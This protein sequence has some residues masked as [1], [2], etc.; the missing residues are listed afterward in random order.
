SKTSGYVKNLFFLKSEKLNWKNESP[1]YVR[2]W[3]NQNSITISSGKYITKERWSFT[4]K[5]K[6]VL[7]LEREKMIRSSLDLLQLSIEKKHIEMTRQGPASFSL[8][9]LK[10]EVKGKPKKSEI[11]IMEILQLHI[12]YFKKKASIKERS[13][14]TLQKYKRSK[15]LLG[16]F[17][18]KGYNRDDM[19]WTKINSPFIHNLESFLKYESDFNGRIGIKN[20]SVVKYM[21][22]YKTALIYALKMNLITKNLFDLYTGR[23]KEKNAVFLTQEELQK[24]EQKNIADKRLERVK[25][26]FIFCCYTGYAPI[27]VSSL[28]EKNLV[29]DNNDDL[30]IQMNRIK[31]AVKS[32]V[33]LLPPVQ[34]IIRKYKGQQ[35]GLL[36]LIS[37]QKMNKYLK[38]IAEQC[39]IE[40]NL[41]W[42][43]ARHT[44]VTT[45]TLGNDVRIENVSSMMG[46]TNILQTQHYAKVFDA[47]IKKDMMK[48]MNK[49]KS[50]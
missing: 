30:W 37:N 40:K 27:D 2:I 17:I 28:T 1:I 43:N 32:N 29:L 8:K 34:K 41:T 25:D 45:V 35:P 15:E 48:L 4:N 33:P 13:M 10:E 14:A 47:S 31:T 24:I 42:Y 38:E 44:F 49:Y 6:N 18:K 21:R 16:S 9:D 26:I 20:N 3:F 36:P 19:P 23:L 46:H 7:K 22:M 12:E 11:S 50:K 39:G 5:L